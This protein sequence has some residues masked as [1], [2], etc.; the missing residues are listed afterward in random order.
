MFFILN[1]MNMIEIP[2][3]VGFMLSDQLSMSLK[4]IIIAS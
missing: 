3:I 2:I 4:L 1:S